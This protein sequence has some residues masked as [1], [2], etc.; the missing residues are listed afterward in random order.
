MQDR[1]GINLAQLL[2]PAGLSEFFTITEVVQ[3]NEVTNITL[4]EKNIHP[5]EYKNEKLTSKGFFETITVQ[6]FP[7]R[8]NAVYLH[9]RRRRWDNETTGDI[10]WRDWDLVA[11]G[12]RMTKEFASFLKEISRY[13]AGKL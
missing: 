2:L 13:Q 11:R 7:L 9:I 6:D 5:E 10:V 4:E 8:G 12:T 3:L 1:K